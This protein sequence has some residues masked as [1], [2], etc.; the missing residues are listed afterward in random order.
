MIWAPLA[1]TWIL[2]A[3]GV[4]AHTDVENEGEDRACRDSYSLLGS[5]C[6]RP[7]SNIWRFGN[8]VGSTWCSTCICANTSLYIVRLSTSQLTRWYLVSLHLH[9]HAA[10]SG[11]ATA[12][13]TAI[14]STPM[15]LTL[16]LWRHSCLL[17]LAQT[18]LTPLSVVA[19]SAHHP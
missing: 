4:C 5:R 1:G 15:T 9:H 7:I 11:G 10:A 18:P 13:A 2:W 8:D 19:G 16:C 14:G 3:V 17:S 12:A 6:G